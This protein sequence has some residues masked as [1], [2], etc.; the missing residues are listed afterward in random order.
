MDP[1][2][3]FFEYSMLGILSGGIYTLIALGFI[4]IFKASG[5][6]NFA[7]GE[8][9]MA[10][11]YAFYLFAVIL[12]LHWVPSLAIGIAVCCGLAWLIERAVLRPM[13]GQPTIALVMVT[14]GV[15][16]MLRGIATMAFGSEATRSWRCRGVIARMSLWF[17]VTKGW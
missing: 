4:L 9:M 6:F 14:F 11:T 15:G 8:M 5:V 7:M 17:N 2:L 3:L 16:F 1:V 13:L 10:G 12:G